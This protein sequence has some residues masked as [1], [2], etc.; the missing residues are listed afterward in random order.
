MAN[1]GPTNISFRPNTAW[2]NAARNNQHLHYGSNTW[3]RYRKVLVRS[4]R[5]NWVKYRYADVNVRAAG[6]YQHG[7]VA[8]TV[9]YRQINVPVYRPRTAVVPFL[10]ALVRRHRTLAI[11]TVHRVGIAIDTYDYFGTGYGTYGKSSR[12][13]KPTFNSEEIKSKL[14]RG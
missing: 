4:Y 1:F 6:Q 3:S 11:C 7:T 12:I 2:A 5:L 9:D 8:G 14:I 13:R 10:S